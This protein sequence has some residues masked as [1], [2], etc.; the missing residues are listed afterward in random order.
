VY[1]HTIFF[2]SEVNLGEEQIIL[3]GVSFVVDI[4]VWDYFLDLFD[5]VDWIELA[6][7]TKR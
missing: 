1:W 6:Q 2:E 5:C 4:N 7:D 3:P